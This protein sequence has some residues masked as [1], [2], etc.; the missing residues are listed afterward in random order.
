VE[1]GERP[2]SGR[3]NRDREGLELIVA[4]QRNGEISDCWLHADMARMR[5][6]KGERPSAPE[7][8]A[9]TGFRS[10]KGPGGMVIRGDFNA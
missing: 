2:D 6:T 7:Q 5:F 10:R 9:Q 4:K 3:A 8:K 1:A